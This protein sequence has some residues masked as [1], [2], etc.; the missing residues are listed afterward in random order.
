M[1]RRMGLGFSGLVHLSIADYLRSFKMEPPSD[2]PSRSSPGARRRRFF[3]AALCILPVALAAGWLF[4]GARERADQGAS[5]STQP[6]PSPAPSAAGPLN[7]T[8]NGAG[9]GTAS[10]P[11]AGAASSPALLSRRLQELL[12]EWKGPAGL[13]Q[14]KLEMAG[15]D[16]RLRAMPAAEASRMI[17]EFLESRNDVATGLSFQLGPGGVLAEAP[18]LRTFLIEELAVVDPAR[19]ALYS[20][21]ILKSFDSADEWAL[22]FRTLG[23]RGVAPGDR[24]YLV[25]RME[26]MLAHTP[27][28][29]APSV[30]YLEA[31]DLAVQLRGT[32]LMP[33]LTGLVRRGDNPALAHAAYLALDRLAIADPAGTLG[34]LQSDPQLMAGREVTRANYFARADVRDPGQRQVLEV[35]LL[36]PALDPLELQKFAGLYPN[37]NYMVSHN[38]L[39]PSATPDHDT[40]M[41]RDRGALTQVRLWSSDPRFER[42]KPQLLEIDRRLAEFVRQGAR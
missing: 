25:A 40:L 32:E 2:S 42:L 14:R 5:D 30:G 3:T 16:Q 4:R 15:L 1:G 31:F 8:G 9:N 19:A 39:T 23:R 33:A 6:G 29:A 21:E 38:L 41:A 18:T 11:G 35:Y 37:A 27:W 17:Q 28:Q 36:N 34:V 24:G 13:A 26:A 22:A 10:S 12:T 7:E 20:R